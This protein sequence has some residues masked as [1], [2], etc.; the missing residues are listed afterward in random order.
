MNAKDKSARDA[1]NAKVQAASIKLD[2]DDVAGAVNRCHSF[3]ALI[4]PALIPHRGKAQTFAHW[5][6]LR[7]P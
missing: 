4:V 7:I 5:E 1:L 6:F 3:G 2:S